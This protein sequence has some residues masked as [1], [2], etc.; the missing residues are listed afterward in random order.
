MHALQRPYSLDPSQCCRCGREIP[1][2]RRSQPPIAVQEEIPLTRSSAG[3]SSKRTMAGPHGGI[4]FLKADIDSPGSGSWLHGARAMGAPCHA[5]TPE[6]GCGGRLDSE[7]VRQSQSASAVLTLQEQLQGAEAMLVT[8][9]QM[10]EAAWA[11]ASQRL[12]AFDS[13]LSQLDLKLAALSQKQNQVHE[14]TLPA[15]PRPEADAD[16]GRLSLLEQRFEALEERI[17]MP[18]SPEKDGFGLRLASLSERLAAEARV[19]EEQFRRLESMFRAH[20]TKDSERSETRTRNAFAGQSSLEVEPTGAVRGMRQCESADGFW[21]ASLTLPRPK[22][23][24]CLA[25]LS[26]STPALRSSGSGAE[27]FSNLSST[28]GPS[29]PRG[30]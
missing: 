26:A 27:Q 24:L 20:L 14:D 7:R 29:M 22:V 18:S 5:G 6:K 25:G 16:R 15:L 4:P 3:S 10:V 8:C 2:P 12:T 28:L 19:R 11:L 23:P 9:N 17:S 13:R 21:N 1:R 30:S